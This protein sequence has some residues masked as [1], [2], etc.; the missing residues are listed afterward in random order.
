MEPLE[1]RDRR[2]RLQQQIE[3]LQSEIE[4][5]QGECPHEHRE[6]VPDQGVWRCR[7]CDL[8]GELDRAEDEETSGEAE[9]QEP[10]G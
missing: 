6:E 3:E 4:K 1:I 10:T 8:R 9:E 7:D 5:L 2:Y